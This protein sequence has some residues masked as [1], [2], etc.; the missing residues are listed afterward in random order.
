MKEIKKIK[1][2]EVF[3]FQN[4]IAVYPFQV[5]SMILLESALGRI[6]LLSMGKGEVISA[7]TMPKPRF[8]VLIQGNAYLQFTEKSMAMKKAFFLSVPEHSFYSVHAKEDSIFLEIEYHRGGTFMSEIKTIQHLTRAASFALKDEISYGKGQIMSKNLVM[9]P[10]MV[11]TLMSFDQGENLSAHK[12]PGDALVT[13]LEGEAKFWIDGKE[14]LIRTGE[15]IILPGNIS[16]AVEAVTPFKMLLI[17]A[18]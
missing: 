7:E 1:K 8:F 16:H 5:S 18:K 3:L 6:T 15:N 10:S 14:H 12:A 4:Q 13:M 11:M 17:I 2:A 9:N